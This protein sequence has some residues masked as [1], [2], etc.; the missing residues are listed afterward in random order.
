MTSSIPSG[1]SAKQNHPPTQI[2]YSSAGST[3]TVQPLSK[4]D[5]C[6]AVDSTDLAHSSK[7]VSSRRES[8][9]SQLPR[10]IIEN[11]QVIVPENE[12][13]LSSGSA[14]CTSPA[15]DAGK[16]AGKKLDCKVLKVMHSR[17]KVLIALRLDLDSTDKGSRT[18][19]SHLSSPYVGYLL[20]TFGGLYS[21]SSILQT[22]E[23]MLTYNPWNSDCVNL[24]GNNPNLD[25][26][27]PWIDID[28]PVSP[29][30][31]Q[32]VSRLPDFTGRID[33][34][35]E[36]PVGRGGFADV[37][38]GMLRSGSGEQK[39]SACQCPVHCKLNTPQVAVKV[40]QAR[41]YDSKIEQKISKVKVTNVQSRASLLL[42]PRN[43]SGYVARLQYGKTSTT[44]MCYRYSVS[45][46]ILVDTP[47][48]SAHG[49]KT[50]V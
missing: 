35:G 46:L 45:L 14:F 5:E 49:W 27:M 1:P 21:N 44:R 12:N 19:S 3:G 15:V 23:E 31:G 40:L 38:K 4:Q 32:I 22:P 11:S 28:S 24:A 6:M 29:I 26:A 34:E 39:V 30:Q 10:L 13:Q 2:F 41:I 43:F 18:P 37:W 42:T 36:Y 20:R 25:T 48:S 8:A 47:H 9:F 17:K 50:E 33:R 7:V 16:A